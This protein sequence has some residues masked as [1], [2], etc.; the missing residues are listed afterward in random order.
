LY[1][2]ETDP[3]RE[4]MFDISWGE[5]FVVLGL[6]AGLIGRKDL[7]RASY[8]LGTQVGRVVGLLQ[9]ARIR[10]DKF[11]SNNDLHA[12]QSEL[13]SG[14]RELDA[15]K[16]E[17]AA[18]A[19]SRSIM[20]RGLRSGNFDVGARKQG[21]S[22]VSVSSG[23]IVEGSPKPGGG[24]NRAAQ[25][26]NATSTA[27]A[28]SHLAPRK[29]SVAAVAEEAWENQGI[30]FKSKAELGTRSLNDGNPSER[31]GGSSLLSD[32]LQQNLIH[33]Q[34]D[35]TMMEQDEAMNRR[36]GEIEKKTNEKK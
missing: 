27:D 31:A 34:Y 20:G 1:V 11:A 15:V 14:L 8:F 25:T 22:P 7:P 16:G 35:R 36:I 23:R 18:A 30:G 10:A 29:N 13:R 21:K 9:G 2:D 3:N 24:Y 32:F 33:D 19:S 6:T 26:S 4:I 17:L 28:F 12:L 5:T